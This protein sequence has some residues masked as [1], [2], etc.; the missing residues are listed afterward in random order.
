MLQYSPV[1]TTFT[2]QLASFFGVISPEHGLYSES[3]KGK[4]GYYRCVNRHLESLI[5]CPLST[6]EKRGTV[7]KVIAG[8]LCAGHHVDKSITNQVCCHW[9]CSQIKKLQNG[10]YFWDLHNGQLMCFYQQKI[11][12]NGSEYRI[13]I[14]FQDC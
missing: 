8:L 3:K 2:V 9:Y 13:K 11:Y 10:I 7:D 14:S 12:K 1:R 5:G 4:S 6:T